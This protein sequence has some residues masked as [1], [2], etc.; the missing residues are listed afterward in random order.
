MQSAENARGLDPADRSARTRTRL[1]P[2]QTLMSAAGVVVGDVLGQDGP[3]ASS[4]ERDDVVQALASDRADDALDVRVLPG[5]LRGGAEG[6]DAQI[7]E[8]RLEQL[9]IR[10]VAVAQKKPWRL[11]HALEGESDL[12]GEPGISGMRGDSEMQDLPAI[13][14]EHHEHVE[15]PEAH[16]RH[17]EQVAGRDLAR[18][19]AEEGEPALAVP[20][21]AASH[22]VLG[23]RGLGEVVT[24]QAQLELEAGYS[25]ERILAR[26]TADQEDHA[27]RDGRPT[28]L[29][30]FESPEQAPALAVPPNH[31]LRLN[32]HEAG[33][34]AFPEPAEQHPE[35]PIAALDPWAG[36]MP[37]E[38][39][40]LD[41]EGHILGNEC[42]PR[43][44]QAAQELEYQ[45]HR[46][47][48]FG[49]RIRGV[50]GS[51]CP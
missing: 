8:S 4:R 12:T 48:R 21:P 11:D 9:S 10:G 20:R 41:S 13:M 15:Q 7:Q 25:P 46:N 34:P 37:S 16:R 3:K 18:M 47:R 38:G 50:K 24:E 19:I 1:S 26:E 31:G 5:R 17:D 45:G 35:Q 43:R 32:E 49:L 36:S 51:L 39:V 28:W 6:L 29:A 2:S 27:L 22:S 42:G 44:D 23:D 33:A 14:G 40:Q 30:G